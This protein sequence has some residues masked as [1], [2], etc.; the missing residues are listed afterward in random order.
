VEV[1]RLHVA[2]ARAGETIRDLLDRTRSSWD[3]QRIAVGN[4]LASNA[5]LGEGQLLKVAIRE[6]YAPAA[7]GAAPRP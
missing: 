7:A 2:R 3:V 1:E 5:R 4:D 6:P